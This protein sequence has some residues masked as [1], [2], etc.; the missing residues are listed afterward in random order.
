MIKD[1]G[2]EQMNS[3]LIWA[4]LTAFLVCS[5]A[6]FYCLSLC[7]PI[8]TH[9]AAA[10]PRLVESLDFSPGALG[11]FSYCR[12]TLVSMLA[13]FLE[14]LM[15]RWISSEIGAFAYFKNFV[16]IA[17]F[18]GFGLG[19][20]IAHRR[21]N[22]ML[23]VLPLL[24]LAVICDLP[25]PGLRDLVINLSPLLGATTE[26]NTWGVPY[27]PL[28]ATAIL[29]L[30]AAILFILPVFGL[31]A[32]IFIP[33]GQLVG[34]YLENAANGIQG[35]TVNIAGSLAGM[36]LYTFLC[37]MFQPPAI[38]MLLAGVMLTLLL[39]KL[40]VLRWVTVV[41]FAICM[42]LLSIGPGSDA[43]VW[44]SP[45]QKL[46]VV[47]ARAF[48]EKIGYLVK[49]NSTWYQHMM[50]LS[51]GFVSSH[52]RLFAQAPPEWNAYNLP[53]R[54]YPH[55][56]SVLVLGA[57]SGNDVAAALRNGAGRVVAVEIDPLILKLGRRLHPERPYNSPRVQVV[58]NDARSYVENSKDHFDLII[59]ALLDSHTTTSYYSNIRIDNY[60]YTERAFKAARR[61]LKPDG[62]MA[63]KFWMWTPWISGR[64]TEM[65]QEAF[66]RAPIQVQPDQTFYTN[67]TYGRFYI[68]GSQLALQ[69]ALAQ[70]EI[71]QYVSRHKNF[72]SEFAPVT[73]DNWPYFYQNQPGIPAA[74]III[75]ALLVFFCWLFLR[76]TGTAMRSMRWHFFF[77]GAGFMLLEAQIISRLAL[78]F[79]TTWVVNSIAVAGLLMLIVAANFLV[80][81]KPRVPFAIAY[82]GIFASIL[83][84]YS[85]PL[86]TFFFPSIW[87]KALTAAGVLCLPVFFAGIVFIRSFA[88]DSFRSEAL[89][90]NLFG[91]LVGGMLESFS[92][93]TGMR[94]L[95]VLAALLY[96]GSL[97]ALGLEEPVAASLSD[98]EEPEVPLAS[99]S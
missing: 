74:V 7:K 78:L 8:A 63:V 71:A 44:W 33:F 12:L 93:W 82:V 56:S 65:V 14:L 86:E 79:G 43:K 46:T 52:P 38:W 35:Y 67:A 68:D 58:V 73:T 83:V 91:A 17:C 23:V 50:N 49:T 88:R 11:G 36:A 47:P 66:G 25:W 34:W 51:P 81:W 39:W 94:S 98:I 37:F 22:L 6:I 80:E 32:S 21:I 77:L 76:E 57:G 15:I 30:A 89:G 62:L 27:M 97:I 19:C 1:L 69:H 2:G 3:D 84:A 20:H 55:P 10:R 85:V 42:G 87:I 75:S 16:L 40:E 60:V 99:M 41:T 5:M 70:P 45:Y 31:I 9:E 95:L 54:F 96:L 92:M 59:F 29:N 64:M 61:L 53:Y 18:L 90:S 26:V 48:G 13:L 72:P 24:I 28:D 4:L